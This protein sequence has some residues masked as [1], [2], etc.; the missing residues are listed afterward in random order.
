MA[1]LSTFFAG[2]GSTRVILVVN[3]LATLVNVVL[4]YFWIFGRG[5]FPALGVAGAAGAT[6]IS[7]V[8]GALVYLAIILKKKHRE[9]YATASG[10]ALR[11]AAL[12]ALRALRPAHRPPVL[13]GDPGLRAS[14]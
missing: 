11:A 12:H 4:D 1:T 8:V 2:R 13:R 7:Q 10:L 6:V 3:V 14:S 5:G 9:A